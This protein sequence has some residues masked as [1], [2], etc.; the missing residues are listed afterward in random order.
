MGLD[1]QYMNVKYS[2]RR[3]Y[4]DAFMTEQMQ[5]LADGSLVLD[6]GGVRLRKRGQFDIADYPVETISVNLIGDKAPHVR[7]DA[8]RLPFQAT[9]FDAAVCT[10]VLE[11]VPDPRPV[12]G[13]MYRVLK[14]GGRVLITVPFLHRIHGDPYD[15]GRYTDTFWQQTLQAAGFEV[16][17]IRKQGLF[18]SV[19]SDMYRAIIQQRIAEQKLEFRLWRS[20]AVRSMAWG[21]RKALTAEQC[22]TI[23]LR[24]RSAIL[25]VS[26]NRG[27]F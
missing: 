11:H 14:P 5:H 21:R 23:F 24:K 10:E 9:S 6:V 13:E 2:V 3:Y 27:G 17:E 4:V 25:F 19:A 16:L 26:A 15:F 20:L 1:P 7:A 18:W 22:D 8:A 12:I